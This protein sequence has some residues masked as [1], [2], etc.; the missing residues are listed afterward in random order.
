MAVIY[1]AQIQTTLKEIV[2]EITTR[3][4]E[5]EVRIGNRESA[6]EVVEEIRNRVESVAS[7]L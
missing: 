1:A 3:E 7:R 6:R 4:S 2:R 5:V